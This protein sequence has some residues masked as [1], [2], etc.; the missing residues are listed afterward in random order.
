MVN[1]VSKSV[2]DVPLCPFLEALVSQAPAEVVSEIVVSELREG[3]LASGGDDGQ[4][5]IYM[6][7]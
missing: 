6:I 1:W 5:G 3:F 2:N 4:S 7:I